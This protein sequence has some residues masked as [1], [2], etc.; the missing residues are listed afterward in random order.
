MIPVI[1]PLKSKTGLADGSAKSKRV[2]LWFSNPTSGFTLIIHHYVFRIALFF[3]H[4]LTAFAM[5]QFFKKSS[6]QRGSA[7]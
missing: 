5:V 1:S 4:F 6:S 7:C 3:F 2:E